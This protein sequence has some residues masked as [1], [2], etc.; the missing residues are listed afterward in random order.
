MWIKFTRF[1]LKRKF[2]EWVWIKSRW[3]ISNWTLKLTRL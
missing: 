2:R 3:W 1:F